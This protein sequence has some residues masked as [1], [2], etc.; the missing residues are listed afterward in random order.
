MNES[1]SAAISRFPRQP[2]SELFEKR[3][4]RPAWRA[5]P[6]TMAEHL[7]LAGATKA[8]RDSLAR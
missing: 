2:A 8:T 6:L 3:G 1:E 4:W 7:L 5:S